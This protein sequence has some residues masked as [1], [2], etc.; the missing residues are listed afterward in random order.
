MLVKLNPR[1][2]ASSLE[3]RAILLVATLAAVIDSCFIRLGKAFV[4]N[5]RTQFSNGRTIYSIGGGTC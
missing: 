4:D 3:V 2:L 5:K 1:R